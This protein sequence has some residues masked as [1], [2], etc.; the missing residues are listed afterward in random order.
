MFSEE[1]T[2]DGAGVIK[3]VRGG[4]LTYLPEL[5]SSDVFSS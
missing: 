4:P 2:E 5:P 1:E 3:E